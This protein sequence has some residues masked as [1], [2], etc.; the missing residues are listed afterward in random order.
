MATD[1]SSYTKTI[2]KI[3]ADLHKGKMQPTDL[4]QGLIRQIHSDLSGATAKGYGKTFYNYNSN[5]V[6]KLELEQNVFKFSAAKTYQEQARLNFLLKDEK[7][8]PRTYADFKKEA[9]KMN[10][11][12]NQN[13]LRTEV[14]TFNRAGAQSKKWAKYEDQKG[15]YPN[16][17]YKTAKD[18]RVREEHA[19]LHNVIKPVDDP[20]WDKWY[21][22]NGW[23][24]RCYTVQT[25]EGADKG[26]PEGNPTLGFHNN[27][28]KTNQPMSEDHPYYVFPKSAEK[29]LRKGFEQ[30][31]LDMPLYREIS[32]SG[33]TKLEASLWADPVDF[34]D[35][36][37]NG[38]I[39]VKNLKTEVKIRPNVDTSFLLGKKN[40]E[41]L[42]RDIGSDL[43]V[44]SSNNGI[45]NG[46]K[47][48][49]DQ[50]KHL[51]AYTIV[52][53]LDK[54]KN[55]DFD[56]MVLQIKNKISQNR[57]KKIGS[58]FFVRNGKAAE[59]TREEIL[60][61]NFEKLEGLL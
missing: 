35:N 37:A 33:K 47:A 18:A 16:L 43:K 51:K 45:T 13:Y 3:A 42:V 2:E 30:M 29:K 60:K 20:F 49:R 31:K 38:K 5:A 17:Q 1:L 32:K 22:L 34:K 50:M 19:D 26:T 14:K 61:N 25:R 11:D 6:R 40:Y 7:G 55:P 21:P 57:G 23:N 46:F 58:I 54:I 27:V 41:Y 36:I 56:S 4:N 12:F 10:L 15:V 52:F 53:N 59:M 39:L 9:A 28:G 24:C 44:I 8:N 48:A